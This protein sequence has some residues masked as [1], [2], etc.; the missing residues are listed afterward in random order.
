MV[1]FDSHMHVDHLTG[2]ALAA[3]IERSVAAGVTQVLAVG[4]SADA[5]RC[6]LAA[7]ARFPGRMFAAVG[8]DRSCIDQVDVADALALLLDANDAHVRPLAI[9][10]IGLDFHYSADTAQAQCD[11]FSRQL[12]VA[13]ERGLPVVVHSR[14]AERET[15]SLL[16]Q[17][18][19][20]W[21]GGA[22]RVG[23]MHC[24]TGDKDF[25]RTVLELGL[26]VSFS[27]IVTFSNA[28]E[29]REVVRMVPDDR[30]LI[31]TDAPFLAPEPFRGKT[32]ES[33]YLLRV[34]DVVASVRGCQV[35]DVA[36]T[37][38]RNA[39]TL[40]AVTPDA[41]RQDSGAVR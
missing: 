11:L 7:V 26:F 40:F 3:T 25:A 39:H 22:D 33:A 24:F 9:G 29:L 20:N 41:Q 38:A 36:A 12:Q 35:A 4:G 21:P 28:G 6:V 23:V 13:R 10:E 30:L 1:F 16:K 27:G 31:E 37:P 18:V 15:S 5:N 2:H 14:S 32:N 34:A 17:H 19:A 8:F